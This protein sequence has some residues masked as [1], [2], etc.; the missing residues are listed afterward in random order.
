MKLVLARNA[1]LGSL[2]IG[3]GIL[4]PRGRDLNFKGPVLVKGL[5]LVRWLLD[6]KT[7]GTWDA[8][9]PAMEMYLA[10]ANNNGY[11]FLS[12]QAMETLHN[13]FRNHGTECI[14]QFVQ[15]DGNSTVEAATSPNIAQLTPSN[16][17]H[18]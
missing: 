14:R 16:F 10:V 15:E 1:L 2:F 13:F 3:Y 6:C 7:L 5:Y 8:P 9:P 12:S 18:P 17:L 4:T 11:K